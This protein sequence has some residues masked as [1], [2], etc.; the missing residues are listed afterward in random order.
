MHPRCSVSLRADEYRYYPVRVSHQ[1]LLLMLCRCSACDLPLQ[2]PFLRALDQKFHKQCFVCFECGEA[3]KFARVVH[4]DGAASGQ[5][6]K[7]PA[8]MDHAK[9]PLAALSEVG[10]ARLDKAKTKLAVT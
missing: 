9:A 3:P 10:Q 1:N 2:G 7:M 8:C 5:S 6:I 4:G